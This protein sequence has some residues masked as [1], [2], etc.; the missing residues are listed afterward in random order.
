MFVN[1]TI[2]DRSIAAPEGATILEAAKTAGIEIPSLCHI[3]HVNTASA[4]RICVVEVKGMPTL[5]PACSTVIQEGME[6]ITDNERVRTARRRNL[7]LMCSDHTMACTECSRGADCRLRDLCREY[8]ADDAAFGEGSRTPMRDESM[9]H[10]VRDNEKCILCHR[11]EATCRVAQTVKAIFVNNRSEETRV[12]FG[13]PLSETDCVSCGQCAAACPTGALSV[14]DNTKEVWK[15]LYDRRIKVVAA[16]SSEAAARVGELFDGRR[17][18]GSAGRAAAILRR[19]GVEAVIDPE[20][21]Y[22][23]FNDIVQK[24]TEEKTGA[25]KPVIQCRCYAARQFIEHF[26]PQYKEYILPFTHPRNSLAAYCRENMKDDD[27]EV[28]FVSIDGCAS[29]KTEREKSADGAV[30]DAALT[31]RELFWMIQRSCV[32]SFTA[33]QVWKSMEPEPY[34]VLFPG[35]HASVEHETELFSEGEMQV[36][37]RKLKTAEASGLG[38]VRRALDQIDS[39]DVLRLYACPGGC[40]NGGGMPQK[41]NSETRSSFNA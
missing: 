40:I 23:R 28:F 24:T 33:Q 22:S 19:I 30:P 35:V 27:R 8:E 12:G 4:C 2:N 26:Y 11:C 25:G 15:A 13:L 20:D 14:K 17:D 31:A 36:E 32:S 5:K 34:N 6:V 10:L 1:I 38:N 16:L 21:Y 39:Y 29:A 37:N 3:D 18:S 9:P 7:E 41:R